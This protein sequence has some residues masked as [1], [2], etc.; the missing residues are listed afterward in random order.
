[1]FL[2]QINLT[3]S[4][5]DDEQFTLATK[6][7]HCTNITFMDAT[8]STEYGTAAEKMSRKKSQY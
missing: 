7:N 6:K 3:M 5:T 4:K 1:M 2:N 8:V